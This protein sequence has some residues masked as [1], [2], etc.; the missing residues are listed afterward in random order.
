MQPHMHFAS[1]FLHIFIPDFAMCGQKSS[2]YLFS[3]HIWALLCFIFVLLHTLIVKLSGWK[4]AVQ[5]NCIYFCSSQLLTKNPA[6][7]LGCV[8]S[9]DGETAI[10]SHPFFNGIDWE[11]LNRRELEPPFKPRIVS[12]SEEFQKCENDRLKCSWLNLCGAFTEN[13]RRCQQ[14]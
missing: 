13:A 4:C 2:F 9:E 12:P 14:L 8:A 10:I 6:Q 5:I 11:K 3:V 1:F 7:R